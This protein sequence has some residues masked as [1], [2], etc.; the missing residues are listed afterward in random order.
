MTSYID[1]NMSD[2]TSMSDYSSSSSSN[3]DF[4]DN[5]CTPLYY[6]AIKYKIDT[7]KLLIDNGADPLYARKGR[8]TVF[9]SI[10]R[11]VCERGDYVWECRPDNRVMRVLLKYRDPITG[12]RCGRLDPPDNVNWELDIFDKEGGQ[13]R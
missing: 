13:S 6:A 12:E 4:D 8:A 10:V 1:I 7:M 2:A 9:R 11:R 3:G 5:T